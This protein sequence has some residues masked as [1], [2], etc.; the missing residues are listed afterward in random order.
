MCH[1]P[2]EREKDV[3]VTFHWRN[4]EAHFGVV[5]LVLKKH[6]LC[7]ELACFFDAFPG[8]AFDATGLFMLQLFQTQSFH[9]FFVY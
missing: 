4:F 7:I 8:V 3:N 2:I 9:C 1:Y 5:L 6:R